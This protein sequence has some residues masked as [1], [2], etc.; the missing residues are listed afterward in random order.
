M[1]LKTLA[2]TAALVV[3]A[4]AFADTVNLSGFVFD[5]AKRVTVTDSVTP[6]NNHVNVQAGEFTGLLNGS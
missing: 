5:P 3:A 6:A 2:L 1:T 4:P